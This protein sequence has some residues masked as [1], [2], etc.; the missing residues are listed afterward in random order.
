LNQTQIFIMTDSRGDAM[1]MRENM[2]LTKY[3]I[4]YDENEI[5]I[6]SA[7]NQL[8]GNNTA[9]HVAQVFRNVDICSKGIRVVWTSSSNIGNWIYLHR[10]AHSDLGETGLIN[11]DDSYVALRLWEGWDFRDPPPTRTMK[12]R[13]LKRGEKHRVSIGKRLMNPRRS[14]RKPKP[15]KPPRGKQAASASPLRSAPAPVGRT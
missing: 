3:R 15:T 7:A 2:A 12:Q 14:M 1:W 6:F 13:V 4:Y 8:K 11:Y 5:R 10:L 9:A